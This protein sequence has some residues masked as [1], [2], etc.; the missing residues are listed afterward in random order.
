MF[1]DRVFEYYGT[2][3][4]I[5]HSDDYDSTID[6]REYAKDKCNMPD[7]RAFFWINV[8]DLVRGTYDWM[9]RMLDEIPIKC[10]EDL[11]RTEGDLRVNISPVDKV[12]L[13][14]ITEMYFR[15]IQD[16]ER[17]VDEIEL[18]GHKGQTTGYKIYCVE[19]EAIPEQYRGYWRCHM[20]WGDMCGEI[21]IG[22]LE[23]VNRRTVPSVRI[24]WD[25]V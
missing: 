1:K 4:Y 21:H 7:H 25:K 23:R 24:H 6:I 22:D 2:W 10:I 13:I 19:D 20:T 16:G 8:A 12:D 17:C 9:D 18:H 5:T 15:D 11:L 3:V 14:K